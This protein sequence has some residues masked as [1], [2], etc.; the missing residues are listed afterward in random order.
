MPSNDT[1]EYVPF[2]FL[3]SG[4]S[5]LKMMIGFLVVKI[6]KRSAVVAQNAKLRSKYQV[7]ELCSSTVAKERVDE[8]TNGG[9]LGVPQDENFICGWDGGLCLGE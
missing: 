3:A 8:S 6:Q 5:F 4:T 7:Y 9:V 2:N 1:L